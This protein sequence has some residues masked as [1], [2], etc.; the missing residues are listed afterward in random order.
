[1]PSDTSANGR[2]PPD[3]VW[4]AATSSFQIEGAADVD[5]KGLS[6]WDV[7]CRREG[8]IADGSNGDVACDHYHRFGDDIALMSDLGLGAYRFSIAWPRVLPSGVGP[9]NQAG[10][11]FY[12]QLVDALLDAG[13]TPTPTLYHWDLP[14][15]LDETGG[16]LAR[17][18]A[19]AFA[20]YAEIVATRLGDRIGTWMTLNEPF[21][22]AHHGYETGE[23][24]PGHTS[25]LE[26]LTASHHLLLAHGLALERIRSLAPAVEVG[27]VLNFTPADPDTDSEADRSAAERVN[28]IENR[29]YADALTGRGYPQ[30][31][32][33]Y[34]GWNRDE[35]REG[36]MAIVS[37]PIDLLGINYYTRHVISAVE[38]HEPSREGGL[39]EMGWEIHPASFGRLLRWLHERYAFARYLITENG[40]AM[41]DTRRTADGRVDDQDRIDFYRAHLAE[42]A[43]A[44][45]AGVPVEGY[46]AW[47][48]M[49]NFEWAHGHEK[50]FG[51]VEVN[52]DTLER[53]PKRSALWY[54]ELIESGGLPEDRRE[55]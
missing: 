21:V 9:V 4:G 15:A 12:D 13:I 14:Q 37:R 3:F 25:M 5:G 33:D 31:T 40:C 29:W 6:I 7:F 41:P 38:G 54:R 35:I 46:Y 42:V 48:L 47:S 16:W 27:V 19:H 17:D 44:I 22:S 43:S 53:T 26:A 8:T 36:D 55:A 2:F 18:T 32:G 11:D 1:M 51:L 49:D 39:T 10:L 52:Y 20:D 24:A 50:R 30:A 28:D 23:H 34:Y 45:G